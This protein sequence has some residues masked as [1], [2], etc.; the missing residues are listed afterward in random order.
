MKATIKKSNFIHWMFNTGYDQDMKEQVTSLGYGVLETLITG[1]DVTVTVEE[2]WDKC[3]TEI[4]TCMYFEE[5]SDDNYD[6]IG[7]YEDVTEYVLIEG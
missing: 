3:N 6:E 4:I 2:L 5:Y 1:K 7:E